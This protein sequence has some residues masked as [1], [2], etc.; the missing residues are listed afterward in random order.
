MKARPILLPILAGLFIGTSY[1]PFPPWAIL[2]GLAPL[3]VAW[4]DLFQQSTASSM[5]L[6]GSQ[7][8]RDKTKK[9]LKTAFFFGWLT[10][11][12]LNLIGFHWIAYTAV[13]FG[14]FPP[15]FGG[16]VLIAFAALAHL[17]YPLAGVTAFALIGMLRKT[18]RSKTLF[19][20]PWFFLGLITALFI[21]CEAVWPSIFPWHLG[22]TWLW[23]DLPG[24]QFA[25]V[26]GF[27]G[28]NIVTLTANA[29]IAV[30]WIRAREVRRLK[31]S[32]PW[33]SSAL[34][35]FLITNIAGI[36]R[37][38][39]WK[40][41]DRE[42]KLIVV[43]GNIGNFEKL[44]VEKNKDFAQPIVQKYLELTGK[45]FSEHPDATIAVWPETA[46]ADYLDSMFNS[47]VNSVALRNFLQVQKR[48]ILT[49]AYSYAPELKKTFNGLFA[50]GPDGTPLSPPYHKSILI[51]FGEKFPFSDVIPYMK[52]LFPGLGSFGQGLGPSVMLLPEF[53]LGPQIC[54]ESLYPGFSAKSVRA[55]AEILINVTNDSWFGRTFEPYQ[56]LTMTL[57]RAVENRRPLIR[58]TNTGI[59][60]IVLADG[61]VLERS[62]ID[63]EWAG[64]YKLP[65]TAQ[66]RLTFYSQIAGFS[67]WL[68]LFLTLVFLLL[69]K[70][71]DV[72]ASAVLHSL[73]S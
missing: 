21:F 16:L 26:I 7:H 18:S 2:F 56:H 60:T 30:G 58:S 28:L 27:E 11:F 10:Q 25:D 62:P 12:I 9:T 64:Y 66:P 42:A 35:L 39:P 23:A 67:P 61:S 37:E 54:L 19:H 31:P 6:H 45:A 20:S 40:T 38:T 49:G 71:Q 5:H 34:A 43:Q 29:L 72:R 14:H 15:V 65:F 13:E 17:Y 1:I 59:S 24:A 44:I 69:S 70:A 4:F 3:F 48:S 51:P 50:I 33:V 47:Q 57:A 68:G 52:W 32:L 36:G 8:L 63:Q 41:T 55:G 46:F 73:K 53:K 22:Y